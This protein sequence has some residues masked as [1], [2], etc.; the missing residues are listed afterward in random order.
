MAGR[1]Q[2]TAVGAAIVLGLW[3]PLGSLAHQPVG[4]RAEPVVAGAAAQLPVIRD[5]PDFTLID[6]E[7]HGLRLADLRGRVVLISFVYLSCPGACPLITQTQRMAVLYQ[8]LT[9]AHLAPDRVRLLSITVDPQRDERSALARY[10]RAIGADGRMAVPP[11][12]PATPPARP[13][14]LRRVGEAVARW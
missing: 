8:Q 6:Q 1:R 14:R 12:E 4:Q 2:R 3:L 9:S 5:A 13:H 11:R 7:G 10:A